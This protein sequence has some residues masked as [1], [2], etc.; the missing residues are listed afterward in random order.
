MLIAED[1]KLKELV[2]FQL[3]SRLPVNVLEIDSI[4]DA[5]EKLDRRESVCDLV[6]APYDGPISRILQLLTAKK[7]FLPAL[8]YFDPEKVKPAKKDFDGL[9]FLGT[10]EIKN[11]AEGAHSI[12][13]TFLEQNG[14]ADSELPEYC[15]IRTRLLLQVKP[16]Q[17]DIFVRLS[18]EK[19]V[20]IFSAGS[21]FT[22]DDL[23][24]FDSK[25]IEFLYLQSTEAGK[26]ADKFKLELEKLI[27][28]KDLPAT[29]AMQAAESAHDTIRDLVANLGMTQ[30]VLDLVKTNVALTVQTIGKNP[31]LATILDR[32]RSGGNYIS[33]HS[34][35]LAEISCCIAKEMEMTDTVFEK[36]VLASYLHDISIQ[37]ENLAKIWTLEELKQKAASFTEDE[38]SGYR[39]HPYHS[40]ETVKRYPE[41]PV[42]AGIIIS[43]HHER[44]D[45]AGFPRGLVHEQINPLAALFIIAHELTTDILEMKSQFAVRKFVTK[46]LALYDIGNFRKIMA[47]LVK[48]KL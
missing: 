16:L 31:S 26:F 35:L 17:S 18:A 47:A 9:T 42:D 45:G 10:V 6:I 24:K 23:K 27:N 2:S 43:Q 33:S 12:I 41:I 4:Q 3:S 36:L 20:K 32:V 30:E 14:T 40:A 25:D 8:F 15:P 1:A 44:P 34:T 7:P 29:E 48:I 13:K 5:V 37:N 19:F 39:L 46:K 28:T 22:K 38:V 11:I 21:E